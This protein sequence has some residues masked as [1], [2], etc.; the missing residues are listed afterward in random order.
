MTV[1]LW[2]DAAAVQ[3][4]GAAPTKLQ[5]SGAVWALIGLPGG[6]IAAGTDADTVGIVELWLDAAAAQP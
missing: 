3:R 2:L 4:G 1:D 5:A 6:G